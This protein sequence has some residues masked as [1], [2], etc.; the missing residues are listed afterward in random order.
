MRKPMRIPN[1]K[2]RK[3][4]QNDSDGENVVDGLKS[5][6]ARNQNIL[7][8]GKMATTEH[9]TRRRNAEINSR[10][11][12]LRVIHNE[13]VTMRNEIYRNSLHAVRSDLRL[14]E[15]LNIDG[16]LGEQVPKKLKLL[17]TLRENNVIPISSQ[18]SETIEILF[19]EAES[20][21]FPI[22]NHQLDEPDSDLLSP[23]LHARSYLCW[24][25]GIMVYRNCWRLQSVHLANDFLSVLVPTSSWSHQGP[26]VVELKRIQIKEIGDLLKS[27]VKCIRN[28]DDLRSYNHIRKR[29]IGPLVDCLF[30]V[31]AK[32][33]NLLASMNMAD[34]QENISA[35]SLKREFREFQYL[36]Q[37]NDFL[38][39]FIKCQFT[40]QALD[41]ILLAYEGAHV[42]DF[43]NVPRSLNEQIDLFDKDFLSSRKVHDRY[44]SCLRRLPMKCLAPLL[45][46]RDVWVFGHATLH[47]PLA[48]YL[49]TDIE[50]FADVWGPV[51]KVKDQHE[52]NKIARYNVGEGSIIPWPFDPVLHPALAT[53][54]RLCHWISN[55]VFIKNEPSATDTGK[56][57]VIR[58]D[59]S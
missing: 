51:W 6:L 59:T 14:E 15:H 19:F 31:Q 12:P 57:E 5:N 21:R 35:T 39:I 47:A 58:S 25:L 2:G 10:R 44:T 55:F 3:S 20:P 37:S 42:L 4:S 46:N 41:L 11:L 8:A 9:E 40:F 48:L 30:D 22:E 56:L 49:R 45:G 27:L 33:E 43:D 54:E 36:R 50:I 13:R 1:A 32:S 52:P 29:H 38:S 28:I 18:S 34:D 16:D 24:S 7:K 53:G 26:C 17:K 23:W